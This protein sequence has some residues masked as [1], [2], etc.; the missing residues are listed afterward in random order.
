MIEVKAL[1]P[2]VGL[3]VLGVNLEEPLADSVRDEILE[4]WIEAGVLLFRGG[5][6]SDEAHLRLSRIFG[7]LEPAATRNYNVKDNPYLMAVVQ[8][9]GKPPYDATIYEIDGEPI[10]GYTPWHWDQSFMPTIVRG[11]VLR[12]I[13]PATRGGRTGFI[14]AIAAYDRLPAELKARIDNLEVVYHYSTTS[15][16][17]ARLGLGLPAGLRIAEAAPPS[18]SAL[19]YDQFPPTVH[20]LVI[21]QRETGRKVLKYSP[22]HSQYILGIDRRE[23]DGIMAELSSYLADGRYAY[24]HDWA[25]NDMIV[26]DNWRVIHT[27][28]GAPPD[29]RRYAQRTTIAGDY[30]LGRYL[31]RALDKRK[32]VISFAD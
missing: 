19:K 1:S 10:C 3:E 16:H 21:T 24:F 20:P 15:D 29:V 9:P 4:A 31:D 27:A 2:H 18:E 22:L 7:E 32:G 8:D 26:W 11:A 13:E 12:M 5:G 30:D 14:D 17:I 23:S 6:T 28:C 25:E